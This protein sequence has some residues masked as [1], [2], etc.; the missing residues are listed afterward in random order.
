M[1]T[2]DLN[3]QRNEGTLSRWRKKSEKKEKW[4][5]SEDRLKTK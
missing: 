4:K 1:K 5:E 3:E 2:V